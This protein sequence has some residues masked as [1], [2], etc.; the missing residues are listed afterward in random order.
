[1]YA[2]KSQNTGW[3]G[4]WM[5]LWMYSLDWKIFRSL[6]L[7]KNRIWRLERLERLKCL[8]LLFQQKMLRLQVWPR[9]LLWNRL[10][11]DPTASGTMCSGSGG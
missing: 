11:R 10:R 1:M 6:K 3:D 4:G 9:R 5:G 8:L 2:E 7:L